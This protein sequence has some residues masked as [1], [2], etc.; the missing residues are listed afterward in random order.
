M[1]SKAPLLNTTALPPRYVSYLR[2][3]KGAATGLGIAAQRET[4]RS[5][6][7]HANHGAQL[8]EEF[9]EVESGRKSDRPQLLKA[10]SRCKLAGAKLCI[11]K[12][13]RLSRDVH[14]LTGLEKA[15]V[16]FVACDL[17]DANRLSIHIMAAVAQYEVERIS[18]RT[19]EALAQIKSG[20]KTTKSGNTKLGNP[21]GA[22]ALRRAGKGNV[23]AVKAIKAKATEHAERLRGELQDIKSAGIMT[24]AGIAAKL[25]ERHIRPPSDKL[26]DK[27]WHPNTVKR[28]IAR[29]EPT[30]TFRIHKDH[31]DDAVAKTLA[32]ICYINPKTTV[33]PEVSG[34]YV[35]VTITGDGVEAT[36][37]PITNS[38]PDKEDT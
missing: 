3:S 30:T 17:P 19:K 31:A 2:L 15:G 11:A 18:Q 9:V 13:D 16:D 36:H 5:Y 8:I 6:L 34:E 23:A 27:R 21:N 28:L 29:V 35:K 38:E 10:L 32:V 20:I 33:T 1:A 37:P 4:V 14:F 25:N 12:L 7:D 26:G 22:K 24:L